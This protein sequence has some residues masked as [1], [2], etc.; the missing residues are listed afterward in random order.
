MRVSRRDARFAFR[1]RSRRCRT[2]TR[3]PR[4]VEKVIIHGGD[5]NRVALRERR[6][7]TASATHR[8]GTRV[9]R[10]LLR[11]RRGSWC[12][13]ARVGR[14]TARPSV[15][16]GFGTGR[17]DARRASE[18]ASERKEEMRHLIEMR[19][20]AMRCDVRIM[21]AREEGRRRRR[22]ARVGG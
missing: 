10:C 3:V 4:A 19:C 11:R 20:D 8:T 7:A 16:F 12:G 1:G 2:S 15:R 6:D 5:A 22:R 14:W 21:R 9:A 13:K 18:R 17:G